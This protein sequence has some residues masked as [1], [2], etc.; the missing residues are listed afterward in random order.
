MSLATVLAAD[1]LEAALTG[2][3]GLPAA[4]RR[5]DLRLADFV[6]SATSGVG[7]MLAL[8]DDD[9]DADAVALAGDYEMLVGVELLFAVEGVPGDDMNTVF[10]VGVE[11]I[12]DVLYPA[13]DRRP[14]TIAGKFEDLR[15]MGPVERHRF[16]G[17]D[18]AL[19]VEA[20]K[21]R[22]GLL[23]TAPTPFG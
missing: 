4:P 21:V 23:I 13:P 10:N 11:A 19:P 7:F 16:T 5:N 8:A 3:T 14:L 15:V 20:L 12:R 17:S 18:G 1:A 9:W 22:L 2:I 6:P